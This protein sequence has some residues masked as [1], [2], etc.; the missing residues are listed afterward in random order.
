LRLGDRLRSG[1]LVEES[2]RCPQC[3]ESMDLGTLGFFTL[4]GGARWFKERSWLM[5][6]GDPIIKNPLGGDTWLDGF[7]CRRCRLLLIRY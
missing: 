7:R 5:L 4:A 3:E 2:G 6:N 1:V